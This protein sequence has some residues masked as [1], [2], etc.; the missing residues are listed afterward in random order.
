[1]SDRE[2]PGDPGPRMRKESVSVMTFRHL[3]CAIEIARCG[4][5]NKAASNLIV[6]QPYLSG[7][8][9]SLEEEVGYEIFRR[10]K[11][12]IEP[13]ENG[14]EFLRHARI[15]L[16]ELK[17]MSEIGSTG[18]KPLR[19]ASYFSTFLVRKFL[20]FRILHS[21]DEADV[22]REMG[23][24]EIMDDVMYGRSDI[25]LVIFAVDKEDKYLDMIEKRGLAF[26]RLY[27][28]FRLFAIMD[29]SHPL[30]GRESVTLEDMR[31]HPYVS[32]DDDSSQRFLTNHIGLTE[33]DHVLNVSGRGAFYD[34]LRSGLY[35]SATASPVTDPGPDGADAAEAGGIMMADGFVILPISDAELYLTVGYVTKKGRRLS[36]REKEFLNYVKQ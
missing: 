12:G 23:N 35:L 11:A 32:Y 4:S 34:A 21:S 33:R 1:M 30:A 19:V 24:E 3:Q 29:P 25:G 13:T 16:D 2:R 17:I 20:Q 6:S 7:I 22:C 15:V 5:I 8:I 31:K 18:R 26:R 14:R 27:E 10:T 9:K 28:R 36:P